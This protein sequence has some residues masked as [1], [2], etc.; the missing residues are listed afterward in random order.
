[1]EDKDVIKLN[2]VPPVAAGVKACIGAGTG[3]GET[4]LTWNGSEYDV[5]PTEVSL[6]AGAPVAFHVSLLL[7]Q[8]GHADFSPRDQTE[9]ELMEFIKKNARSV[10]L[11]VACLLTRCRVAACLACRL[12]A[13]CRAWA[14]R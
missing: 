9:F 11:A 6:P 10:A 3:L 12:S 4:F 5:W 14:F 7:S 1:M 13:W 2:N 8:G